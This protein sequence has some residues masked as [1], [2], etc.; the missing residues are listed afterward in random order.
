MRD[1]KISRVMN[2]FVVKVGCQILV[3]QSQ[4]ELMREL[5]KYLANPD[6]TE[7]RFVGEFGLQGSEVA[8]ANQAYDAAPPNYPAGSPVGSRY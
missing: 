5:D 4:S 7:K 3:F 1:V 8:V 6:E 2:G